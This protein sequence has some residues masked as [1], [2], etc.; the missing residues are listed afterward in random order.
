M[1]AAEVEFHVIAVNVEF[2][3]IAVNVEFDV[4]A[5]NVEFDVIAVNAGWFMLESL[6]DC[7]LPWNGSTVLGCV[8]LPEFIHSLIF[9]TFLENFTFLESIKLVI[10]LLIE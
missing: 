7:P 5:V 2:D 1:I 8:C 4:I 9:L 3:M 10:I 6:Y